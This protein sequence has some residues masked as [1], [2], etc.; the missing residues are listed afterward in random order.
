[1]EMFP[2][3][4][5]QKI[6]GCSRFCHFIISNVFKK[7]E[8]RFHERMMFDE[9]AAKAAK[10]MLKIS[11]PSESRCFSGRFGSDRG[12]SCRVLL[13]EM[14]SSLVL[15]ERHAAALMMIHQNRSK[16]GGIKSADR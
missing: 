6:T 10:M 14:R 1:M 11:L 5:L 8:K 3:S 12:R 9:R 7:K 16:V 4:E 15:S 2:P 13:G